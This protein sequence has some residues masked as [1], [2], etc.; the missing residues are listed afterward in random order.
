MAREKFYKLRVTDEERE[1]LDL[2]AERA[3]FGKNV[4]DFVRDA[5]A[6]AIAQPQ[7]PQRQTEQGPP[8]R[9]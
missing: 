8:A 5:A 3:G 7:Q 9:P 2:A 1:A 4:S 6:R